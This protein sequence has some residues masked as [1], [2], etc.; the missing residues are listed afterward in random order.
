MSEYQPKII[1]FLCN[2]CVY[3][4]FNLPGVSKFQGEKNIRVIRVM[5]SGRV[6]PSIVLEA[7]IQ[8]ADGVLLAGCRFGY[9]RYISG[10]YQAE[11]KVKLTRRVI[12]E[13][14][15][16]PNRLCLEWTSPAEAGQFSTIVKNFAEQIRTSGPI[17]RKEC[18]TKEELKEQLLTAQDVLQG[19]R[20]RWFV[21]KELELVTDGNVYGEKI[22]QDEF[23]GL[24]SEIIEVECRQKKVLRLIKG[25]ALSALEI[26]QRVGLPSGRIGRDIANM[27]RRGI[28]SMVGVEGDAP[29]FQ[30]SKE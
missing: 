15:I 4:D 2:W 26:A 12:S 16:D 24:I 30:K 27:E 13:L 5:C 10:N 21:G 9:C 29:K 19:E 28:I 3:E 8:G 1:V 6:D 23:D 25:Q 14:G 20:L 7:F 18:L 22:P 11:R 17:G